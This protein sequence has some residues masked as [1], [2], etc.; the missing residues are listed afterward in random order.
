MY[1]TEVP[2]SLSRKLL[3]LAGNVQLLYVRYHESPPVEVFPLDAGKKVG[4][5]TRKIKAN[6]I[7]VRSENERA[8]QSNQQCCR[9]PGW[10]D[11]LLVERD[12]TGDPRGGNS[13]YMNSSTIVP[14]SPVLVPMPTYLP[15]NPELHTDPAIS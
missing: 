14:I 9:D 2:E 5:L 8:R 3:E 6:S 7:P 11:S 1:I 13:Y 4:D 10:C 15:W 12:P